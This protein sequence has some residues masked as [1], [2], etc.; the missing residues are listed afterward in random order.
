[1]LI[2]YRGQGGRNKGEKE[3]EKHITGPR[4]EAWL[5]LKSVGEAVIPS[6]KWN[7]LQQLEVSKCD[8][9]LMVSRREEEETEARLGEARLAVPQ[10][11]SSKCEHHLLQ[12]TPHC[13]HQTHIFSWP[14]RGALEATHH[15]PSSR[16]QERPSTLCPNK[17]AVRSKAQ[18]HGLQAVSGEDKEKTSFREI[19]LTG[20]F[21]LNAIPSLW[22]K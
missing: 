12:Q 17:P 16:L 7:A 14:H 2:K 9:S 10:Q 20:L 5:I 21:P 4:N 1:M 15:N 11:S 19:N 3:R 22:V 6:G 13:V 8:W 18:V